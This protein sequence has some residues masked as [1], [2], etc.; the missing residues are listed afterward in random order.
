VPEFVR[1]LSGDRGMATACGSMVMCRSAAVASWIAVAQERIA[2]L[3]T[4]QR[5]VPPPAAI[6]VPPA[7]RW[8]SW[9]R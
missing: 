5:T 6:P 1:Q 3:L 4:D 7:R 9:R 8:W 2:A